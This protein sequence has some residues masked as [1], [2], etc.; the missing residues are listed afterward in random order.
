MLRTHFSW[1]IVITQ[2]AAAPCPNPVCGGFRWV[3]AE[4]AANGANANPSGASGHLWR[5]WSSG[6]GLAS[7]DPAKNRHKR[8][9]LCDHKPHINQHQGLDARSVQQ[10]RAAEDLR[11]AFSGGRYGHE[12]AAV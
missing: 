3:K 8:W 6:G 2:A 9:S 5:Q 12:E 11:K 7:E 10:V 1:Y 4:T